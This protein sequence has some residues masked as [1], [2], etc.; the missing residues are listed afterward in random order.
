MVLHN[1]V[2]IDGHTY[3]LFYFYQKLY[4]FDEFSK[5]IGNR[6]AS[7]YYYKLL[8]ENY[9]D[10]VFIFI[11]VDTLDITS[12]KEEN[13]HILKAYS[14]DFNKGVKAFLYKIKSK[15]K[16]VEKETLNSYTHYKL[17]LNLFDFI[18]FYTKA[19]LYKISHK[20]LTYLET[21]DYSFPIEIS[22]NELTNDLVINNK[23]QLNDSEESRLNII[24]NLIEE[25]DYKYHSLYKKIPNLERVIESEQISNSLKKVLNSIFIVEKEN[26]VFKFKDVLFNQLSNIIEILDN[27]D[28]N[29]DVEL[30]QLENKLSLK[31]ANDFRDLLEEEVVYLQN[32]RSRYV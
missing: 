19:D 15:E 12:T 17:C 22:Y 13:H 6:R 31:I 2:K 1:K 30:Y 14:S 25:K 7:D 26:A 8:K 11:D 20:L 29:K 28:Y 3:A 23:I 5:L 9:K 32:I 24:K 27:Y 21:N 4:A 10:E 16:I 18:E